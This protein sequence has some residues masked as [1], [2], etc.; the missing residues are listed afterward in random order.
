M[1]PKSILKASA[2]GA[3]PGRQPVNPRHLAIARHHASVLEDRKRV[4]AEVLQAVMALMDFPTSPHADARRPTPSDARF[5]QRAVVPFQ[6]ADYDAL[7]EERN[8]A[9]KC[10]YA[11]CSR[12]KKKA[13]STAR[14]QFVDTDDGVQIVDRKVLEVWC[15]D[16][17]AKRALYVKV[18]LSEE[19]AW[20][21]QGGYGD[22]IELMVENEDEHRM[23]LPLRPKQD[24]ASTA[25]RDEDDDVKAAWAARE[26]AMA[27]LALER[28]E[29]SGQ[30]SKV[31][32][33]LVQDHIMERQ[34]TSAP[35][36]PPS[37]PSQTSDHTMAIE[38][39]VPRLNRKPKDDGSDDEDE[40]E[41]DAQDWDK[42]L[43]G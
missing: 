34:S 15:S 4:E 21:R 8:I 38:G 13:R 25:D 18:Q 10:G 33:D 2:A 1:P 39:H 5:F 35:P 27:D 11:L 24:T 29:K 19:P 30:V 22:K 16:D 42:H 9:D 36:Q 43:P 20:L 7:I 37:L 28:G 6:P 31:N 41:N 12:P 32:S 3:A 40:D 23:A 14:K 17:C 26:D